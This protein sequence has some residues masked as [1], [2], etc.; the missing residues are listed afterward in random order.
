MK[1]KAVSK[2]LA[3]AVMILSATLQ[4]CSDRKSYAQMLEDENKAVN[5]FLVNHRVVGAVP[6]DNKFEV[7]P[8]APYYQLDNEG[9][10]YMQ[11]LVIG[12]GEMAKDDQLV[13]FRFDRANLNYYKGSLSDM[14]WEGNSENI[15]YGDMSFR[16]NNSSLESSAQ[17]GSGIQEPLKYVPLNSHVRLVVKS[18]LGWTTE[19]AYVI[20]FLYDIRYFPGKI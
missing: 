12:D 7:G 5:S 9:N 6:A 2:I 14:E 13:Y 11:V 10:L 1:I 18:Q 4:G 3:A 8:N 16:L 19:I 17:W 20:P 15:E